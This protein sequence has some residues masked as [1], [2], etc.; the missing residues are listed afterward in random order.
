MARPRAAAVAA[1]LERPDGTLEHSTH[2]FPSSAVAALVLTRMYRRLPSLA[3]RHCIEG[4][5][6]HDT[7]RR[8]DWAV[9]AALLLRRQAIADVGLL[10]E[11]FFMYAED[12]EWCWRARAKGWEIWFEPSAVVRHVGNAS[13]AQSY[14]SSRTDA[15]LRN[16][17][18]FYRGEH[19]P[20][21]TAGYRALNAAGALRNYAGCRRRGEAADAARWRAQMRVHLAPVPNL[22]GPPSVAG[23]ADEI[24]ARHVA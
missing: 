7:S 22:D 12:V 17:Y 20:L 19:G 5:W 6:S 8:V 10:D 9:G 2:P 23:P 11:R 18:R 24:G 1:R 13:G 4:A 14:G 15:Y 3:W 21:A 16:T